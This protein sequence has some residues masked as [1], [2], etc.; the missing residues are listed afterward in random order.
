MKVCVYGYGSM[1]QRHAKHA[2][3][4]GHTVSVI[5]VHHD[6]EHKARSDGFGNDED[7]AEAM[8]VAT[9]ARTHSDV[10]ERH[11][12]LPA[13]VE[14]PLATCMGELVLR[15]AITTVGYNLRFHT[16]IQYFKRDLRLD[17]TDAFRFCVSVDGATWPG[18]NAFDALLECSHEIDLALYLA[19]PATC[20]GALG[21]GPCWD[22]LLKHQSG[23]QS[24]IHLDTLRRGDYVRYCEALG[25]YGARR[26]SWDARSGESRVTGSEGSWIGTV[27]ADDT[28]RDEL[29]DFFEL[30]LKG[31]PSDAATM[32]DGARVLQICDAAKSF[33]HI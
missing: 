12:G 6:L 23:I 24:S 30:G 14:K 16:G 19:G 4:L 2:R 9:P 32:A 20:V 31:A 13:F 11:P 5:D 22:L 25:P 18:A 3:D 28:Y 26:W 27:Q 17:R 8:I 21:A 10:L 15:T 29:A 33:I 7:G 1:G